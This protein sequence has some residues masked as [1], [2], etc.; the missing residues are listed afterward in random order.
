MKVILII[1]LLVFM[2]LSI[3]FAHHEPGDLNHDQVVDYRD[4]LEVLTQFAAYSIYDLAQVI[5][6]MGTSYS[7]PPP[8]AEARAFPGAQGFGSDTIGGRGGQ[9][10][11]VTSTTD[12]GPGS[13]RAAIETS[14]PRYIIFQ[15]GGLIDL[16]SDITVREPFVTLACQTAPGDGIAIKRA[17]LNIATHDVIVRGCRMRVGDEA[18]SPGDQRDGINISTTRADSDVYNVIID[19]NSVAWAID[20]TIATWESSSRPYELHDITISHNIAALALN[21]SIHPEG[22]HSMGMNIGESSERITIYRNLFAHNRDRNPRMSGIVEGEVINNFIYNYGD[23]PGKVGEKLTTLHWIGNYYQRGVDSRSDIFRFA[24][25]V[26]PQS[27]YYLSDNIRLDRTSGATPEEW[28]SI[29]GDSSPAQA[30]PVFT[31]TISPADIAAGVEVKNL[32]TQDVG[33]HS[34]YLDPI[35]QYVLQTIATGTGSITDSPAEAGGWPSYSPGTPPQDTDG[36][37]IPDSA[38][39][40]LGIDPSD[41]TDATAYSQSGYM[42]IEVWANGLI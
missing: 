17:T 22:A 11:A 1:T 14:G 19:H 27:A 26:L 29:N 34:P 20:E 8:P 42:W 23:G 28:S 30:S 24:D 12:S 35:D 31:S 32:V 38:E 21:Q 25:V 10:I 2:P 36:D 6:H 15:T 3:A 37:G 41:A 5:A 4:Y 39:L 7:A 18:G 9:V 16:A 13:L 33:A 40:S